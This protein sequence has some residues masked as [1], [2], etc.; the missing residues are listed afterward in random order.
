[1]RPLITSAK[2][3]HCCHTM[4][5]NYRV[6]YVIFTVLP[7]FS[8]TKLCKV[9]TS[10]GGD[11]GNH[12]IILPTTDTLLCYYSRFPF[13]RFSEVLDLRFLRAPLTK[14]RSIISWKMN[15]TPMLCRM[16]YFPHSQRGKKAWKKT[17]EKKLSFIC[18]L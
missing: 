3:L 5:P 14:P 13:Y 6:K 16:Y 10:A 9:C 18:C 15:R 11:L 8:G 1:M 4:Q 12:L 7:I 17:G 2:S